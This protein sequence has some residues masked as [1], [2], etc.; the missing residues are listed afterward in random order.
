MRQRNNTDE[1]DN[2]VTSVDDDVVSA[3]GKEC[4]ERDELCDEDIEG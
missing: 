3:G 4:E 2:Q 1:E